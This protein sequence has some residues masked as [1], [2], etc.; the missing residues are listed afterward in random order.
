MW[1]ENYKGISDDEDE[2]DQKINDDK[3]ID[4]K[5]KVCAICVFKA[6]TVQFCLM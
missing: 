2:V 3:G 6:L 5:L 4:P 1:L